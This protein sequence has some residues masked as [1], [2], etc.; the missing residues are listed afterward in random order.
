MQSASLS[1]SELELVTALSHAHGG[2]PLGQIVERHRAS[3]AAALATQEIVLLR[4]LMIRLHSAPPGHEA[5]WAQLYRRV[6]R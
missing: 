5:T 3:P 1:A 6:T 2:S 4:H